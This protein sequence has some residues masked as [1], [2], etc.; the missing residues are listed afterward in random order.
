MPLL[1]SL[2]WQ[3]LLGG[4]LDL[5]GAVLLERPLPA[6]RPPDL[7]GYGYLGVVGTVVAYALWFPGLRRLPAAV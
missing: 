2:A 7:A 4:A 5:L 1:G 6:L 3:L